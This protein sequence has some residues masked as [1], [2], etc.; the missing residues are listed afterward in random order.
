MAQRARI[1]MQ[2]LSVQSQFETNIGE[3]NQGIADVTDGKL[4]HGWVSFL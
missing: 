4:L 3:Q 1:F 2:D